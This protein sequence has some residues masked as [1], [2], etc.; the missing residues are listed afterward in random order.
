MIA[1]LVCGSLAVAAAAGWYYAVERKQMQANIAQE[2]SAVAAAQAKQIAFWRGERIADG[3]LMIGSP[4]LESAARIL[5]GAPQPADA[6]ALASAA[7]RV[8][9]AFLYSG[10][11]LMDLDGDV[12][13]FLPNGMSKESARNLVHEAV[14]RGD[15]VL[16]DLAPEPDAAHPMMHLAVPVNAVGA[17][18]LNIDPESFLYPYLA[19]WPGN[20][21]TAES[22]LCRREG[23]TLVYLTRR[24]NLPQ[25]PVFSSRILAK[26]AVRSDAILDQGWNRSKIDYR[27][28]FAFG[29][30]RH[31][32]D[33]PWY[34]ICKIDYAE[35]ISPINHLEW[36]MALF[37]GL[38]AL[39][40]GAAGSL[41]M[42]NQHNVLLGQR[43]AWFR[44]VANDT[45]AYLWMWTPGD[46]TSFINNPLARFLGIEKPASSGYWEVC[47]HQEDKDRVLDA[48][49]QAQKTRAEFNAT[50]RLRRCD[51]EYRWIRD[52]GVP[53]FSASGEFAG[54][55]G[56]LED[57]SER[58]AAERQLRD[59]NAA[60]GEELAERT[61]A[62]SQVHRLSSRLIDAQEEE[63]KR[64]AREL[65]DD[66]NQQIAALTLAMGNLKRVL[67]LSGGAALA[68]CS[69][70][71][72]NLVRLSENVRRVSHQLHPAVLQYSGLPA[73]LS[74]YCD[75]FEALTGIKVSLRVE[76]AFNDVTSAQGLTVYR[77]AQEALQN[78][79]KHAHTASAAIKLES[80]DRLLCLMVSDEGIG[81]DLGASRDAAGLGLVS[82]KERARL[83][84]GRLRV[85]R[86]SSGGTIVTLEIPLEIP[87]PSPI[88]AAGVH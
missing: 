29:T 31:I 58:Y 36:E 49:Q 61:R 30:V 6:L 57:V 14:A 68:Q 60:L 55:A 37:L 12:R 73:A 53:R 33:S 16:S 87:A 71:F 34:L 39:A 35:A 51:G 66:L 59:A 84:G 65:H 54:Y 20:S 26:T 81:I 45:P 15:A 69:R 64:L 21:T 88:T 50:Y 9:R 82:M 5:A 76:G 56:A 43:E 23:D 79:A 41:I 85:E 24:H 25:A 80:T 22:I 77:I 28:I 40:S 11:S 67:P 17:L 13:F 70:I 1:L 72:D 44:A 46:E 52:R 3:R 7:R 8:S 86:G 48:F 62:E 63:R 18:I 4:I 47:I 2:M 78:V 75:E 74:E 19:A 42:R 38:I 83:A 27:G 32:P 10:G